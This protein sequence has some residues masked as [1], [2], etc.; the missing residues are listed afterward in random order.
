MSNRCKSSC[1]YFHPYCN[2]H[3][4]K[5][6]GRITKPARI[7]VALKTMQ[8]QEKTAAYYRTKLTELG[9]LPKEGEGDA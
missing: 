3:Q 6:A 5:L 9:I 2:A 7:C 1:P 8:W 4:C